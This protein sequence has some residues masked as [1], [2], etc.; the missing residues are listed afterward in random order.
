MGERQ[1]LLRIAIQ[2]L[3]IEAIVRN[4]RKK[5]VQRVIT[6][7]WCADAARKSCRDV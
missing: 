6:R 2:Q 1:A 4:V 7:A 3:Q 5:R